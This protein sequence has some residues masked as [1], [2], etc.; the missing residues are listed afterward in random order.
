MFPKISERTADFVYAE[1]SRGDAEARKTRVLDELLRIATL[2]PVLANFL[3]DV[4]L[5]PT[6][7]RHPSVV[8]HINGYAVDIYRLVEEECRQQGLR[9]PIVGGEIGAPIQ[10]EFRR[11]HRKFISDGILTLLQENPIIVGI[12]K[13]WIMP[14]D[15]KGNHDAI[16][17]VMDTGY[18]FF[19]FLKRQ[20]DVNELNTQLVGKLK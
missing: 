4:G 12:S 14:Y 3:V 5:I 17:K 7:R 6:Y 16:R 18:L 19:C 20:W 2:N 9:M 10:A 11:G 15:A 8:L 13:D 1:S